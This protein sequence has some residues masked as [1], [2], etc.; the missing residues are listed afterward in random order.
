M[1]TKLTAEMRDGA[2]KGAARKLRA[3]GRVP[4]VLYGHGMQPLSISVDARDL[5]H[6]LHTGAGTNVLLDLEV[7]GDVH[8]AIPREVQRDYIHSRYLHV[9]FLAVRRDEKITVDVD[10]VE[11]GE[12]VGVK[13]GGVVEHHLRQV[14]VECFP[15]DVPDHIEADITKLEIGDML[16][17]SDLIAPQGV[18]FLTDPETPVISVITPAALR[19]EPELAL[20]GEEL[21]VEE[22]EVPEGEEAAE[23]E[24]V[25][26]GGEP[27]E[28]AEKPAAEEGGES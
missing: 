18:T 16:H 3:A 20:P 15:T 11:A 25:A 13:E 10:I 12:S 7:D 1:E 17:I 5:L 24:E 6:A 26:E 23:G 4:A 9:D 21:P 14:H 8:L 27:A 22:A 28:G 19:L 2:G